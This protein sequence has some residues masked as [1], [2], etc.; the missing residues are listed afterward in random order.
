M[1]ISV[2]SPQLN[3]VGEIYSWVS[4][5]WETEYNDV[6]SF[7]L[8]VRNT[9]DNIQLLKPFNY[10][11]MDEDDTVM[12]IVSLKIQKNNIVVTGFSASYVL[13]KRISTEI[14]SNV[15]AETAIRNLIANMQ[16]WDKFEVGEAAGLSD[17]FADQVSDKTILDYILRICKD[18]D[19][20]F[21][22]IKDGDRIKFV[23]YKPGVNLNGKFKA[24]YGNLGDEEYLVSEKA[25]CNVAIVGGQGEGD[26]RI[27][28]TVGD[29]ESTG[30]LRREMY[31]DSRQTQKKDGESDASYRSRL[32][33]AGLEKLAEAAKI[34]EFDFSIIGNGVSIGDIVTVKTSF[35]QIEARVMKM[36]VKS[37]NNSVRKII[38][39]GEPL[40]V[41]RR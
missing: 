25:Y 32:Q 35:A 17:V 33:Q 18:T 6:G 21:T 13:S 27:S 16:P 26:D 23:L 2:F 31:V 4:L 5:A 34:E 40:R 12:V 9:S 28:V 36:S 1:K 7:S 14:I 11:K 22:T 37:Q 38:S 20:G 29:A 8:E 15:N 30:Y 10:V 24:E 3:R 19:I 41:N 39:V